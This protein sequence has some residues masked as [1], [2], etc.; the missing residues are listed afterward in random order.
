MSNKNIK[1]NSSNRWLI[2]CGTIGGLI[3]TFSWIVQEAFRPQ[4]NPMMVPISSLAI[5]SLGWIQSITFLITGTLLVLFAYGLWKTSKNE[6]KGVSKWGP[7][8]ILICGIGLIGAGCF[9][10]DPMN[11]YPEETPIVSDSPTFN[12]IMHQLF[13]SFL[14]F[15]LPMACFVFGN[16]FAHKKEL[17][18]LLYSFLTGIIFLIMFLITSMGFSQVG[19]LQFYAGLLQRITLTIGFLWIILLSIYFFKK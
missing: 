2:L 1:F 6:Y 18:W 15:G 17:K 12:S 8:L 19:G 3:F 7:I 10:T 14:F 9:T 16:Y 11:G 5:G 13:S 4:Y